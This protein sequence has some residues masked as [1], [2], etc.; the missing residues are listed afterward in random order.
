M[1]NKNIKKVIK[2]SILE[3]INNTFNDTK[4]EKIIEKHEVKTHFVPIRYRIFGGLLQSLNIQFGNFIEVLMH[5]I[6][7]KEKHLE[8]V[9]EISGKKNISLSLTEETDSLIDRFIS[10]RQ[11][12]NNDKL[13]DKFEKL[14]E[15]III[16]QEPD[17]NLITAKHDVDV[18]FRDRK[19]NIYYYVEI[20]YNDDHDTD[21]FVG[22]NRKFLKTYAGLA[23]KLDIKDVKRLKPILY[24]LNRKVMKGNIYVP[25]DK[26]IYRGEK[27][28]VEFLS[29]KY[30][31][32]DRYLKNV[33]E[34]KETLEIFDNVYKKI[35]YGKI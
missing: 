18:L 10:D 17:K 26:Y 25:E 29:V 16:T 19:S 31:D 23:K 13:S 27:L 30:I 22:I 5:K 9:N 12:N 14:L 7:E 35:R 20:K 3:L 8:I 2:E 32:V 34:D 6:I 33:S 15:N 11:N 24:Y 21:K 4:I 1:K 28:F